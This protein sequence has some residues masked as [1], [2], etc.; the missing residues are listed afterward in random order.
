MSSTKQTDRAQQVIDRLAERWA[1]ASRSPVNCT[2]GP[3]SRR[4]RAGPCS[5]CTH[6]QEFEIDRAITQCIAGAAFKRGVCPYQVI[7]SHLVAGLTLGPDVSRARSVGRPGVDPVAEVK[8]T[9]KRIR[10][11][12]YAVGPSRDNI[13]AIAISNDSDWWQ[14]L[15]AVLIAERA[16]E[17]ALALFQSQ[18][19]VKTRRSPRGRT[20]ALHIQAVARALASAWRVLTGRLPAKDNSQF[21][22]LLLAAVATLFGHPDKEPNWESATKTAVEHIKKDAPSEERI[23]R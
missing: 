10:S 17:K 22:G 11:L 18:N 9:L 3:E 6:R 7:A 21:H 14:A 2:L 15:N 4:R 5:A 1:K 19:L 16:L 13:E 12:L 20:G 23:G 8:G